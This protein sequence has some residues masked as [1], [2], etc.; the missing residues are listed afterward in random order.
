MTTSSNKVI[1]EKKKTLSS[2]RD[3]HDSLASLAMALVDQAEKQG[4]LL[5]LDTKLSM[6]FLQDQLHRFKL[7]LRPDIAKRLRIIFAQHGDVAPDTED[8]PQKDL[9]H[10]RHLIA[11]EQKS[12]TPLNPPNK[13]DEVLLFLI[14]QWVSG[15]G[16]ITSKSLEDKV[17]CNYRTVANA[18]DEMEHAVCRH[19]DRSVSLKYFPQ[20][21]WGR[22]LAVANRTRS[23]MLYADVSDQPHSYDSL[24]QRLW[25]LNIKYIAVGGVLGA[26]R[27]HD[28][29][30]IVGAPRLDLCIHAP[31]KY[32]NLDFMHA[33]DPALERT[34]DTHR[35]ARVALHF[36]R[37]KDALFDQDADGTLWADPVE[38]LL[39]LYNAR[40]EQQARRFQEFL[41]ARA[42]E[43]NGQ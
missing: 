14:H 7:A 10:L 5:I 43:Q 26:K 39:N 40:L 3:L 33:L 37:R 16:N 17:G 28:D 31:E 13:K 19:S 15:K 25:R 30:D 6:P 11:D 23:T 36:I 8:T 34:R 18:I 2:A 12:A 42:R 9:E 20:Q 24:L 29:L 35:P 4:Y 32:V 27:F 21:D 38:C 1:V 41:M 22:L